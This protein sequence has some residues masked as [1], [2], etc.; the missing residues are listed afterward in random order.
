MGR[1][2]RGQRAKLK[3]SPLHAHKKKPTQAHHTIK[4]R[5][6]FPLNAITRPL[7]VD[8]ALKDDQRKSEFC[9]VGCLHAKWNEVD[10]ASCLHGG[11]M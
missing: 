6:V 10:T 7:R 3:L 4:R 2:G 8:D 5:H 11:S 9:E 1:G